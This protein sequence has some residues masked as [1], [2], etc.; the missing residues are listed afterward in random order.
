MVHM[1]GVRG[2]TG[3]SSLFFEFRTWHAYSI[4]LRKD[5][6][7]IDRTRERSINR[8]LVVVK[9]RINI[10]LNGLSLLS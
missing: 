8:N 10:V 4:H 1:R 2:F 9:L 5:L 6:P 3:F 7:N